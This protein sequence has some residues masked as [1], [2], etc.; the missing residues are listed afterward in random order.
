MK[1]IKRSDNLLIKER[2]K[3]LRIQMNE[4]L[5]RRLPSR[6]PIRKEIEEDLAKRRAG[7]RGEQS[8]EYHLS[9]L[10]EKDIFIFHDLRLPF[11]NNY[12]QIDTLIITYRFI[13]LIEVKNISG[14][15][16]FDT[17][18]KQLIRKS[19]DKEEGFLDPISQVKR[20][21]LQLKLWLDS[22]DFFPSIP[23]EH[24][25]VFSQPTT[26]LK[27]DNGQHQVQKRVIHAEQLYDRFQ[28]FQ[29]TYSQD[30]VDH[31]AVKKISRLLLKQHKPQTLDIL[32]TYHIPPTNILTGAQCESC[33]YLPM[34]RVYSKW[35]CPQC[36]APSKDVYYQAV[37]DYFLLISPT[38]TNK[39]CR[40]FL[41]LHS[42]TTAYKLL[43]SM[44]LSHNGKTKDR[45]YLSPFV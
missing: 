25:V 40:E 15:L 13:L 2:T 29:Q 23:L 21:K 18:F 33:S 3:P 32:S 45:V 1:S 38:I 8:I 28:S 22:Y 43:S 10:P 36:Q 44:K 14:T 9:F 41:H 6:D 42:E 35:V 24:L 27:A 19:Q 31:R 17:V 34:N 11:G 4:A 12:F 20:Q 26:V 5:L 7:H 16:L 30:L 37:L 39:Q